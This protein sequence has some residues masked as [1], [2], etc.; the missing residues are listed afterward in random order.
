MKVEITEP[1]KQLLQTE[2]RRVDELRMRSKAQAE[3][4]ALKATISEHNTGTPS[5]DR[6]TALMLDA[7]TKAYEEII[8]R[9]DYLWR[10]GEPL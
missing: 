7:Q 6:T 2:A 1:F 9:I 3:S 5:P 10:N 8:K 4:Y